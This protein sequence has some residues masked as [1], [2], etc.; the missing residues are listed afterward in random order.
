MADLDA[1]AAALLAAYATGT[2]VPPL[3][4]T[5]DGLTL[6]DAYAIQ[7][8]QIRSRLGQGAS[9]AGYKVGLTSAAMRSRSACTSPTSAIC[10]P[11]CA[12]TA[13]SPMLT[14][15]VPAAARRAG[16]RAGARPR[17]ARAQGDRQPTW[18]RRPTTPSPRSRS[19]TAGSPTGRSAC[20]TPSPTTPPAAGSSLGQAPV[21]LDELDLALTGCV[22]R[23]N[24]R[25]VATGAGA[26]R[27]GLAAGTPRP[28]WPTT[29]LGRGAELVAGH[30]ILTG[31]ITAAIPVG[32]G[33]AVTATFDRLGQ[34]HGGVRL[35][36]ASNEPDHRRDRRIRQHRHRPDGQ[37]AA[38]RRAR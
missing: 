22:F 26:A 31:S 12:Y 6:D 25:I 18:S 11:T 28:G 3:T 23:R 17:A 38:R 33:D 19:S 30:V 8:I 15:D 32:P 4:E 9:V 21:R 27:A 35:M 13:D 24:G 1:L 16:D 20:S 7:Q 14:S 10:S 34:R 2:P 5:Y 37:A 29:L 36:M